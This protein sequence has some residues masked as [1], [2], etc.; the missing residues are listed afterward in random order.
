MLKDIAG[1]TGLSE[2][3]V[4]DHT[5]KITMSTNHSLL[6]FQFKNEEGSQTRDFLTILNDPSIRVNQ[7][8]SIRDADGKLFKYVGV[9]RK[10]QVGIIQ[11]GLEIDQIIQFKGK[12][13]MESLRKK[14]LQF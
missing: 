7:K 13:A 8:T 14:Y 12:E 4:L 11:C 6:G 1:D 2:I 9:S 10:D 5:G 3:H